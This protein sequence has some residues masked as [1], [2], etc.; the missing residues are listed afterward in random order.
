MSVRLRPVPMLSVILRMQLQCLL[1]VGQ[2]INLKWPLESLDSLTSFPW[3]PC[4]VGGFVQENRLFPLDSDYHWVLGEI[5][6]KHV[7]TKSFNVMGNIGKSQRLRNYALGGH[8]KMKAHHKSTQGANGRK[9]NFLTRVSDRTPCK[10]QGFRN[11][12]V[13]RIYLESL[14]EYQKPNLYGW[15]SERKPNNCS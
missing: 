2:Q 9:P 6:T 7:P 12:Y 10:S 13:L 1:T 8:L 5:H 3:G 4:I 15:V 14:K 11:Q